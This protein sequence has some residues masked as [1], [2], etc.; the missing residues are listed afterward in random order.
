MDK[1]RETIACNNPKNMHTKL[2]TG[3]YSGNIFLFFIFYF[4]EQNL[5]Q[6]F[7]HFTLKKKQFRILE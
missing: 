5:D 4:F 7:A 2:L 1:W 6:N 3:L